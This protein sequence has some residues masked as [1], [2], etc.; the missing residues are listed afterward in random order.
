[1][2]RFINSIED[3]SNEEMQNIWAKILAG[4][5]K[6]PNTYSLRTIETIRNLTSDEA[7]L[8]QEMSQYFLIGGDDN[9][10]FLPKKTEFL[11][12]YS[13]IL[14]LQ[15]CGLI[16]SQPSL[17]LNLKLPNKNIIVHNSKIMIMISAGDTVSQNIGIG[18]YLLTAVGKELYA[19][20]CKTDTDN[21]NFIIDYARELQKQHKNQK[22]SVHIINKIINNKIEYQPQDILLT[23]GKGG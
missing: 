20:V 13:T 10:I 16:S 18:L 2:T 5:I 4:E 23:A 9:G 15:E 11:K 3:I 21:K 8:F 12:K 17:S 6:H 22:I 19:T 7:K 1:M 14:K